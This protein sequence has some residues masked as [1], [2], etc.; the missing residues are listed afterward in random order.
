MVRQYRPWLFDVVPHLLIE[1]DHYGI[2]RKYQAL[3][4]KFS[5]FPI[6]GYWLHQPAGRKF[7][8][9][10]PRYSPWS[11]P[12]FV[13]HK[14]HRWWNLQQ[15]KTL[16]RWLLGIQIHRKPADETL[17]QSDLWQAYKLHF[18]PKKCNITQ[19]F[20]E[21]QPGRLQQHDDGY[22]IGANKQ[23]SKPGYIHTKH[24]LKWS[25]QASIKGFKNTWFIKRNFHHGHFMPHLPP[26]ADASWAEWKCLNRLRSG[27]RR[28]KKVSLKKWS[29]LKEMMM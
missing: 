15:N 7:S 23:L 25:K 26:G 4:R 12:V 29:F 18:N 6:E 14:W 2:K 13:I 21:T 11:S 27:T 5:H 8:W 24:N 17:L 1:L 3:D 22:W 16:C 28:C 10:S 20:K 19:V 9:H